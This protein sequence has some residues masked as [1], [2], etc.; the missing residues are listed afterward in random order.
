MGPN[1][2]PTTINLLDNWRHGMTH[3]SD[4]FESKADQRQVGGDHYRKDG[5]EQHWTRQ[6]RLHGRGYFVGCITKYVER[7]PEKN[8]IQDLEKAKHFL[9]KLIELERAARVDM[10]KAMAKAAT[11]TPVVD[12]EKD[13]KGFYWSAQLGRYIC[14]KCGAPIF[15]KSPIHAEMQHGQCKP[16]ARDE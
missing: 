14:R 2:E 7:Y 15:A 12:E 11:A 1:A 5:G 8:G 10:V 13:S 6:W 16:S 4:D 9:E 3:N